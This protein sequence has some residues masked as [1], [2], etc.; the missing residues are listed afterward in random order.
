MSVCGWCS[1]D[2]N[3]D[4]SLPKLLGIHSGYKFNIHKPQILSYN[5]FPLE[6]ICK[7]CTFKWKTNNIKYLGVNIPKKLTNIVDINYCSIMKEIKTDLGAFSRADLDGMPLTLSTYNRT[8]II[9]MNI[10]PRLLFLFLSLPIVIPVRQ[11]NECKRMIS[12]FI[13]LI[14]L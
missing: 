2:S 5:Y 10:L 13:W 8:E 14:W 9:K 4:T 7:K 11:F 3:P 1:C 6:S 12:R